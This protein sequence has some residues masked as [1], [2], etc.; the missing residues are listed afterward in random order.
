VSATPLAPSASTPGDNAKGGQASTSSRE[1]ERKLIDSVVAKL[2]VGRLPGMPIII[3]RALRASRQGRDASQLYEWLA[4]DP[5]LAYRTL[6]ATARPSGVRVASD[7]LSLE[8]RASVIEPELVRLLL[9]SAVRCSLG[10]DPGPLSARELGEFWIHALRVAFLSRALAEACSYKEPEEAYLAGLLHDFG[11]FALLATV[12]NTLRSLV[13]TQANAPWGAVPE[14]AG[15]LG[16]I[17]TQIGAALLERLGVPFYVSDAILLHHAPAAELESTHPVVRILCCAEALAHSR[18]PAVPHGAMADLLGATA[19][20]VSSAEKSAAEKISAVLR[21]LGRLGLAKP[22]AGRVASNQPVSPPSTVGQRLT[23]TL[24]MRF[25]KEAEQPLSGEASLG[26]QIGRES[27]R[28]EDVVDAAGEE[29]GWSEA[30]ALHGT[31]ATAGSILDQVVSEAVQ[32][33]AKSLLRS[34][35]DLPLAVAAVLPLARVFA[36]V[37]C[38]VLFTGRAGAKDWPGWLVE[39]GEAV[40][41]DLALSTSGSSCVAR[42]ARGAEAVVSFEE[43]KGTALAGLDLQIARILGADELAAFPLTGA[44][45]AARGV[46]VFGTSA[47]KASRFAQV[48]PF[49]FD[50][51]TLIARSLS[52]RRAGPADDRA[53]DS[54]EQV[55]AAARRL[56]HE[57][58]NPLSVLKTYLQIARTKTEGGA[59]LDKELEIA[60]REV[61]R[62]A[63][64]LDQIGKPEQGLAPRMRPVDV[65]RLIEELLLVYGEAL[66]AQKKIALSPMLDASILHVTCDDETLKQVLLNLLIN[67]SEALSAGDQVMVCSSDHVNY[68]G[69][70]MVEISVADNGPGMPPERVA[71]LFSPTAAGGGEALRGV[72]LPTSLAGVKAMGGHLLCRSRLGEGTTFAILLP[73]TVEADPESSGNAVV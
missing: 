69:Q 73:G 19:S 7:A 4:L 35:T 68:E 57:A 6:E 23:E 72:G 46:L 37:K 15:R 41:V 50:L 52:E 34:A 63:R 70:V 40:R 21:G 13:A 43:G 22:H 10:P 33:E 49:L 54:A 47:M 59:N 53:S 61:E 38:A 39:G 5:S 25:V 56:V 32:L 45:A 29:E 8:R 67:A 2:D 42:A 64:L 60:N 44:V 48:V 62:V 9:M 12:P 3:D 14:H 65:N 30:L 16:T 26:G 11:S 27:G 55:R 18:S 24:V 36:G 71:A 28:N 58:R 20:D 51:A 66:F 17:H 31:N 1:L